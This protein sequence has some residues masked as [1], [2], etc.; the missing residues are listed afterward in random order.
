MSVSKLDRYCA[1]KIEVLRILGPGGKYVSDQI[2]NMAILC[3]LIVRNFPEFVF[4]GFYLMRDG[5]LHIAPYQGSIIACT[6]IEL[7]KGVCGTA[8]ETKQTVIVEDVRTYPNYIAC[9]DDTRSEIVLPLLVNGELI[10]VLDIDC[11]ES[12]FFTAV[13]KANLE[14]ILSLVFPANTL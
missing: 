11:P 14:E 4:T 6:P 1:L 10:A 3:A 12:G 7:G 2:G 8:A 13:D 9:D 5:K